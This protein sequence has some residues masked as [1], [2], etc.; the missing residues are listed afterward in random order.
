MTVEEID[1]R[2][3]AA[4]QPDDPTDRDPADAQ[5]EATPEELAGQVPRNVV[6]DIADAE[7]SS[8]AAPDEPAAV[9][10]DAAPAAGEEEQGEEA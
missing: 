5:F 6:R 1:A 2:A 3:K 4:L 7:G 8:A 9:A 10:A